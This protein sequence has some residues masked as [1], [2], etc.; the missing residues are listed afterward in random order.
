MPQK[1]KNKGGAGFKPKVLGQNQKKVLQ[2]NK[3]RVGKLKNAKA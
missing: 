1:I 2:V 3:N